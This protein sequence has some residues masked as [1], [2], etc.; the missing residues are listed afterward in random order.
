M[1]QGYIEP[2]AAD[3]AVCAAAAPWCAWCWR[4]VVGPASHSDAL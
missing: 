2:C 4:K 3:Q 1:R